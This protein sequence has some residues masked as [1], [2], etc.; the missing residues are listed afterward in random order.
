MDANEILTSLQS[1]ISFLIQELKAGKSFNKRIP[2]GDEYKPLLTVGLLKKTQQE[3]HLNYELPTCM[4]VSS[5]LLNEKEPTFTIQTLKDLITIARRVIQEANK[6]GI[7]SGT[8][9][10]RNNLIKELII[11]SYQTD[12]D[13]SD[14]ILRL[15]KNSRTLHELVD[16]IALAIPL[17]NLP[18]LNLYNLYSHIYSLVYNDGGYQNLFLSLQSFA[19]SYGKELLDLAIEHNNKSQGFISNILVGYYKKSKDLAWQAIHKIAQTEVETEIIIA[20]ANF[21]FES[22]E[23]IEVV[24]RYLSA[25]DVI[26]LNRKHLI[27]SYGNI[28][29]SPH[30][31]VEIKQRCLDTL[32]GFASI[33]DESVHLNLIHQVSRLNVSDEPKYR[34]ISAIDLK[35]TNLLSPLA[36]VIGSFSPE[37]YFGV[38]RKI[39][40]AQKLNFKTEVFEHTLKTYNAE[41]LIEFSEQLVKMLID[42]IGMTRFAG[43]RIL[44]EISNRH[45]PFSF[46]TDVLSLKMGEQIR[47]INAIMLDFMHPQDVIRFILPF[48]NSTHQPVLQCLVDNLAAI[49]EDYHYDAIIVIRKELNKDLSI[50]KEIL[51]IFEKYHTDL[52]DIITKKNSLEEFNPHKNQA[53]SYA[54]FER[55]AKHKMREQLNTG[56][57]KNSIF[58]LAHK[59]S[60]ARGKSWKIEKRG[61]E[62]SPLSLISSAITFPRTCLMNPDEYNWDFIVRVNSNYKSNG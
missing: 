49:M 22:E 61:G 37:Y 51:D 9:E 50:D 29:N 21:N 54:Y 14:Q 12:N 36:W 31:S 8:S 42:D 3:L 47:M 18:L 45:Q 26:D 24:E 4:V 62:P 41:H 46:A 59:V 25:I 40:I 43:C 35:N 2:Y 10:F 20:T 57:D 32:I 56:H 58:E 44:Q 27:W 33:K 11:N 55:L 5:V 28:I 13:I 60:I 23:D 6:Q 19:E 48:R 7:V 38:I 15:H 17:L 53:R 52:S 34:I 16:P 1:E 39:S 30:S